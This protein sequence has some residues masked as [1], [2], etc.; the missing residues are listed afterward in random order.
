MSNVEGSLMR[1]WVVP[2]ADRG[3]SLELRDLP[4]P[5]PGPGEVRLRVAAVSLNPVDQKL[6]HSG[7]PA[8]HYP[9]VPGVDVAG[10]VD[11]VGPGVAGFETGTRV[12]CHHDLSKPG[13]FAEVVC[14][15][16]HALARIPD[17]VSFDAAAAIACA[18]LTA[19]QALQRKMHLQAGHTVLVH[20]GSGG[21]GGYA[22]QI[23]RGLGARVL[24]TASPR[25]HAFV[26]ALGAEAA[27]DYRAH[28]LVDQVRALTDGAGVHAVLDPV[29]AASASAA[30]GLLRFNGQLAF[31]AGAPDIM[32]V[33]P[34]A[35]AL[36]FHAIALGGAYAAGDRDAQEDLARMGQE[37]IALVAAGSVRDNV[38]QRL[39]FE[40]LP[41][42][43]AELRHGGVHGKIVCAID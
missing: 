8:W 30:V 36:S 40:E 28:D 14:V 13:T 21:V 35:R 24:A 39:S 43:L 6:V 19:Y 7:H 5:V 2:S 32:H 26:R 22:I 34:F 25:N 9:H 20:G 4:V 29:S 16:A 1:A 42:G 3:G 37:L 27:L 11:S 18:G 33:R 10:L 23:A 12:F 17:A 41:R 31:V 15:A 38:T